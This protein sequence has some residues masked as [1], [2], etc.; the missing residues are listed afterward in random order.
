MKIKIPSFEGKCDVDAYI[1]WETKVEQIWSCHNFPEERK[2]QLAALEFTDYLLAWWS[3]LVKNRER[4]LDPPGKIK[5]ESRNSVLLFLSP[6]TLLFLV[7][8]CNVVFSSY[9]NFKL[10]FHVSWF[11]EDGYTY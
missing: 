9:L 10:G 8:K 6:P 4:A 1:E 2:V 5:R 3:T 11:L 7:R